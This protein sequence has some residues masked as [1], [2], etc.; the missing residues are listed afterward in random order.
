MPPH[1][2]PGVGDTGSNDE[3]LDPARL[4]VALVPSPGAP[5]A[6][7]GAPRLELHDGLLFRN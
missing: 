7:A 4:L 5:R 1:Q 6:E 3:L 2:H